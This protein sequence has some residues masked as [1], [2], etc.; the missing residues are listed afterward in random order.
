MREGKKHIEIWEISMEQLL[1]IF[2]N[3]MT[4]F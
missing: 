3:D 1:G 4:C 2:F